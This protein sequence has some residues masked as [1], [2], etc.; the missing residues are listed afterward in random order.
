MAF[1][2]GGTAYY[3]YDGGGQRVR[4]V[5]QKSASLVEERISLGGYEVFRR[6]SAGQLKLERQ[7]LHVMDDQQRIALVETKTFDS[8]LNGKAAGKM[9]TATVSGFGTTRPR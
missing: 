9:I 5:W 8:A 1:G 3:V 4:K 2:G 7:T 6:R